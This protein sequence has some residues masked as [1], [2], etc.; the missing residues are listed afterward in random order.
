MLQGFEG[1]LELLCKW[2]GSGLLPKTAFQPS[3]V[4]QGLASLEMSGNQSLKEARACYKV[5]WALVDHCFQQREGPERPIRNIKSSRSRIWQVPL[6]LPLGDGAQGSLC[7]MGCKPYLKGM[8]VFALFSFSR[9]HC[10]KID[11]VFLV[12]LTFSFVVFIFVTFS[13]VC[14]NQKFGTS[15]LF[16]W[17]NFLLPLN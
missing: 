17:H 8:S 3:H 5:L 4:T 16:H 7:L 9:T 14:L 10:F 2:R 6:G 15:H 12:F 11:V 1:P 13:I